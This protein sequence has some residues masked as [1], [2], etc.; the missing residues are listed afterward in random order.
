MYNKLSPDV[1]V[2]ARNTIPGWTDNPPRPDLL[3]GS[4]FKFNLSRWNDGSVLISTSWEVPIDPVHLTFDTPSSV[5]VQK[6]R[7]R[8]R[9]VVS[10]T[11][12]AK[13]A[14]LADQDYQDFV[15]SCTEVQGRILA[16]KSWWQRR[17]SIVV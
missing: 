15:I 8:N 17:P 4:E 1:E 9:V 12:T 13:S 5:G 16:L 14:Y 6:D 11:L 3:V 10:T 2:W 7:E